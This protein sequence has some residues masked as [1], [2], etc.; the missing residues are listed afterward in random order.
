[1]R[2]L[3]AL[4]SVYSLPNRA[5]NPS[6]ES[7]RANS[8]LRSHRLHEKVHPLHNLKGEINA[9]FPPTLGAMFAVPGTS[10]IDRI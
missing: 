8:T 5:L 4:W 6:S 3:R 2:C 9:Q 10:S 1:M 7:R